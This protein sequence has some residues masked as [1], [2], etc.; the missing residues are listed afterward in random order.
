VAA[1]AVVDL[2][3]REHNRGAIVERAVRKAYDLFVANG[4]AAV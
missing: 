2:N 3:T 1:R 4:K